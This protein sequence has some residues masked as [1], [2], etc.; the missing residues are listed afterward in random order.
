MMKFIQDNLLKN[1]NFKLSAFKQN[2]LGHAHQMSRVLLFPFLVILGNE[3]FSHIF[4]LISMCSAYYIHVMGQLL[5]TV[6]LLFCM[7]IG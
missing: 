3:L 5:E 4:S 6:V 7:N 1:N 2:C